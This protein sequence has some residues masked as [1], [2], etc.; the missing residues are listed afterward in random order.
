M[1]SAWLWVKFL[2][3]FEIGTYQ[4]DDVDLKNNF[5]PSLDTKSSRKIVSFD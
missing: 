4:I 2:C 5:P 3:Q 1:E